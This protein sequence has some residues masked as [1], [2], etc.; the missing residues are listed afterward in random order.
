MSNTPNLDK[1][2]DHNMDWTDAE[3][4]LVILEKAR[5]EYMQMYS[6]IEALSDYGPGIDIWEATE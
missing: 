2:L 6:I 3:Q 1:L 5:K 4:R